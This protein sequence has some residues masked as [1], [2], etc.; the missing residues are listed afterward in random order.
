[1]VKGQSAGLIRTLCCG[2]V[3]EVCQMF[4]VNK[5]GAV[6]S[7]HFHG[8]SVLRTAGLVDFTRRFDLF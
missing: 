8:K 7:V 1:M 6:L 3:F 4:T 2:I 5:K